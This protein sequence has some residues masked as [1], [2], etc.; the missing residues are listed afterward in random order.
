[1]DDPLFKEMV[2]SHMC[3]SSDLLGLIKPSNFETQNFKNL[4]FLPIDVLMES[5]ESRIN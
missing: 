2:P 1:M 5:V 3:D 4:F